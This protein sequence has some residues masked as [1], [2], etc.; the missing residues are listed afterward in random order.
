MRKVLSSDKLHAA[1]QSAI[2]TFHA[3]VVN[4][5]ENAVKSNE[6]VVVGMGQNPVVKKARR[7][8]DSKGTKYNYLSYGNYM[9]EWK[10]RLAIKLWSGWPTYPQVF[11][12][13]VLV[14]GATE[15]EKYLSVKS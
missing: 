13:G 8:L 2:N 5:V 1:A 7:I 9:S 3:D 10:K 11:H 15:L 6:W 14:G 4:E 12:K